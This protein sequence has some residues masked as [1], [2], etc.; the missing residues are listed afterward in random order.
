MGFAHGPGAM[1]VMR[2]FCASPSRGWV[3][4]RRSRRDLTQAPEA[5][6]V[7]DRTMWT[8]D[9]EPVPILELETYL[10]RERRS[11]RREVQAMEL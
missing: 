2:T 3:S 9:F 4:C 5:C 10:D 11:P 1:F 6:N 8:R 7:E